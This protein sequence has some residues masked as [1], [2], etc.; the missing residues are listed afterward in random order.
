VPLAD[1]LPAPISSVARSAASC[2]VR[3]SANISFGRT[4]T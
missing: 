4:R 1:S 2:V 3:H